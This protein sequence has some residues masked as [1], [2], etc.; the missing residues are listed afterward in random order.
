MRVA[1]DA[2]GR[3]VIPKPMREELGINGPSELELTAVDGTLE[4][5]VPYVKAHLEDRDGFT[6]IVPDEPV[7][8]MTSE[9][10][11]EAI[12][13]SRRAMRLMMTSRIR[14][15]RSTP[16]GNAPACAKPSMP[17]CAVAHSTTR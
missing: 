12:D 8:P 9:M 13:R 17:A 14:G 11:R 4:L 2:V 15:S 16:T 10:V 3:I 5:T 6:V 7:P 1:I